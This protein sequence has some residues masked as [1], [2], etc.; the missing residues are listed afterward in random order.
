M[1]FLLGSILLF[2]CVGL[3]I[4]AGLGGKILFYINA[5]KKYLILG[6]LPKRLD[7]YLIKIKA[8]FQSLK[9]EKKNENP[10]TFYHDSILV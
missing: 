8:I 5:Q 7:L 10:Y 9:F 6:F 2:G 4:S 1:R 3:G